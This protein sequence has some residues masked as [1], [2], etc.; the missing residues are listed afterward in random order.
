[1]TKDTRTLRCE[2]RDHP[3]GKELLLYE[4]DELRR[5]E[6]VQNQSEI[7]KTH[8]EWKQAALAKGW[9]TAG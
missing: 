3:L 9:T 7:L 5:S 8:W 6:V 2:L 4:G 1:M